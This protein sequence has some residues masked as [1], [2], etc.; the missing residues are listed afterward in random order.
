MDFI[1][2]ELSFKS[3]CQDVY[4]SK[5]R[6]QSLLQVCKQGR[7]IGMSRLAVRYDFYEQPLLA[8]YTVSDW[9][10]DPTVSS[11]LKNLLLS[12]VRYPYIDNNDNL[13]EERFISSYAYLIG[14]DTSTVEG[15]AIAYLYNTVAISFCSSE[16]WDT[17]EVTLKFSEIGFDDQTIKINHA[18]KTSHIDLHKN[19][20]TSRV[21]ITLPVAEIKFDQKEISLRDDHGKDVL[22]AYSRKLIR[23][24]YVLKVINS[25]PFNPHENNF[26][27]QCY[28][29]GKIEIVLTRSDE[30]FGIVIQTTGRNLLETEEI[31]KILYQEFHEQY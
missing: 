4:S 2:N 31:G 3:L 25:L 16:E 17:H 24:Q 28:D 9:L 26:L 20:I 15:L 14:E 6:M 10:N 22:L 27:R 5:S 30:G 13:I 19:W 12:I 18:S 11:I 8:G 29:D 21:G 1:F 23:S 7:E